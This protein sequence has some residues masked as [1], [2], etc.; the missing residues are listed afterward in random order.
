MGQPV[1]G[2]LRRG[3]TNYLRQ[4]HDLVASVAAA[5]ARIEATMGLLHSLELASTKSL[6]TA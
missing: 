2:G 1:S 6:W 3:E 4:A 5:K